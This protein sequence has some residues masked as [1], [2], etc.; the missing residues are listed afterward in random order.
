MRHWQP[1]EVSGKQVCT[2]E[3]QR[4]ER[5]GRASFRQGSFS[6]LV[7]SALLK[8]FKLCD[9]ANMYKYT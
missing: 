1:V 9:G 7:Q 5:L 6:L 8:N 2:N 4:R 3:K